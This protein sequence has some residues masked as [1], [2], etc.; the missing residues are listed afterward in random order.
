MGITDRTDT[1][2]DCGETETMEHLCMCKTCPNSCSIEDLCLARDNALD[3]AQI[4]AQKSKVKFLHHKEKIIPGAAKPYPVDCANIVLDK[5]K[6]IDTDKLL[7]LGQENVFPT[8]LILYYYPAIPSSLLLRDM[9]KTK[10]RNVRLYVCKRDIGLN[11]SW[12]RSE[13]IIDCVN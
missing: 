8:A 2:C 9:A 11:K 6:P 5:Y 1:M 3:V 4:R 10:S 7:R 12:E 13:M